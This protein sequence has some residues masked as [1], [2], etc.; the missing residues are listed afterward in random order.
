MWTSSPPSRAGRT[1]LPHRKALAVAPDDAS[2]SRHAPMTDQAES[3]L[4]TDAT[5][6]LPNFLG[7]Q[8][9]DFQFIDRY[10]DILASEAP[11]LAH[12]FYD[13]LLAHPATAAVFQDFSR[14]RLDALIQKQAEHVS[15]LL[16]SH[17]DNPNSAI[18]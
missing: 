13:Y 4:K 8:D 1:E 10:R 6:T 3:I 5:R 9:P 7:L 18:G 16:S 12:A 17:L 2:G 14:A 15:G 11:A